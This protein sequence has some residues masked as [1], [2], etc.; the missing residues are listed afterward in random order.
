M[1][2]LKTASAQ[3]EPSKTKKHFKGPEGFSHYMLAFSQSVPK[4]VWLTKIN[5]NQTTGHI[6]EPKDMDRIMKTTGHINLELCTKKRAMIAALLTSFKKDP[7]LGKIH[8]KVL[9]VENITA[10]N[11]ICFAIG[12]ETKSTNQKSGRFGIRN[13]LASR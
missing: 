8:F 10:S 5:V 6:I 13:R 4:G 3:E 1:E 7:F 12:T 11:R 9:S 2:K